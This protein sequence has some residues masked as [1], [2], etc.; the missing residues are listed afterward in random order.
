[1]TFR[2]ISTVALDGV[3][4]DLQLKYGWHTEA[5]GSIETLD[6]SPVAPQVRE[7]GPLRMTNKNAGALAPASTDREDIVNRRGQKP[8]C[9]L[10]VVS[11]N[12]RC[13]DT[14][15]RRRSKPH[16]PVVSRH[17][18]LVIDNGHARSL[19]VAR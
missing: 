14:A 8:L 9:N 16:A 1:V 19:S 17:L 7:G 6:R 11:D 5:T 2:Q 10:R 18:R 13:L 3:S 15:S 12:R 4:A